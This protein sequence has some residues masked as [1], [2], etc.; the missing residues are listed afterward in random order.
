VHQTAS[1]RRVDDRTASE[2]IAHR[3]SDPTN[4]TAERLL[5]Q[6]HGWR[7]VR[8]V[9]NEVGCVRII[10]LFSRRAVSSHSLKIKLTDKIGEFVVALAAAVAATAA[11]VAATADATVISADPLLSVQYAFVRTPP[12][13][14][15]R[16]RPLVAGCRRC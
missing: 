13:D 15:G 10:S 4:V 9:S 2:C 3:A 5:Q 8:G 16:C 1:R 6:L 7:R 12:L 14:F 11:A